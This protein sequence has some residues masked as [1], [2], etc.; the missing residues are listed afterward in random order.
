MTRRRRAGIGIFAAVLALSGVSCSEAAETDAPAAACTLPPEVTIPDGIPADFPWPPDVALTEAHSTKQ[1][2]TLEGF[3]EG[4]VDDFF[5]SAQDELNDNGFD[6]VNTDYEGFEAE[7]YFAKGD[8]LAGIAALREAPC[9]GYVRV[10]VVYDPL[11]TAAGREA[12]RKTRRLTGEGS[13]RD[14]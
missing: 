9:D 13:P 11:D 7:L 14:D 6:I 1:F 10:N 12:V 2:I 4:T 5:E 8:G 3:G